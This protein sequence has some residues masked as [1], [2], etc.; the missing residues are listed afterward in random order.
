M[1]RERPR[2]RVVLLKRK[3][4]SGDYDYVLYMRVRA[5]RPRVGFLK[6]L[7]RSGELELVKEKHFVKAG[8]YV[9]KIGKDL[10]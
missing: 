8:G 7:F 5:L 1:D 3:L 2:E 4:K 6:P 9:F 10:R